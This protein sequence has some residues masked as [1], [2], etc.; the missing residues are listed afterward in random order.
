MLGLI[1]LGN[2]GELRGS[3][4]DVRVENQCGDWDD[5]EHYVKVQQILELVPLEAGWLDD[6]LVVS[7]IASHSAQ[8]LVQG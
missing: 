1:A 7:M 4:K 2:L 5:A 6:H 8:L 3:H